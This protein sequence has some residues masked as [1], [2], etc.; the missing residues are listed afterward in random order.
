MSANLGPKDVER[1]GIRD[2]TQAEIVQAAHSGGAIRLVARA[3]MTERGL[4]LTALPEILAPGSLLA[5]ARGTSNVLI[6]E[7]DLMGEIAV[8]EHEPGIG[9][10]AYALLSD[11]ISVHKDAWLGH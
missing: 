3:R 10:T 4:K 9:Q 5:S 1:S 2:L 8:F 7:T 6:I 11:L